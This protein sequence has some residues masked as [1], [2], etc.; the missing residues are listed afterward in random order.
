M[1]MYNYDISLFSHM[2]YISLRKL[3]QEVPLFLRSLL[4][5]YFSTI[6]MKELKL[7]VFAVSFIKPPAPH[8]NLYYV[9]AVCTRNSCVNPVRGNIYV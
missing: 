3:R 2:I 8:K 7:S 4:L 9:P 5:Y 1:L 6:Y